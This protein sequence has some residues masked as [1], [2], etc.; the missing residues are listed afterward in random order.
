M[1]LT[2]GYLRRQLPGHKHEEIGKTVGLG[3]PSSVR[4]AYLLMKERLAK[5]KELHRRVR[6]E[7]TQRH[8]CGYFP[9]Q[10]G[11]EDASLCRRL[12]KFSKATGRSGLKL[13]TQTQKFNIMKRSTERIL[14]T[15][16]G[17]L[18]RS[19]SLIP[20][21]RRMYSSDRRSAPGHVDARTDID[22]FPDPVIFPHFVCSRD[23][24][25]SRLCPSS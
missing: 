23:L 18:P 25:F 7:L 10:T 9:P 8:P 17:S 21:R 12:Q 3:K 20:C 1:L 19:D 4:S 13:G 16:V 11:S 24:T 15:R 6:F 22:I 2:A 14:T 5:E